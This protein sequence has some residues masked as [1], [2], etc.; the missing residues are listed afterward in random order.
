MV[1][2]SKVKCLLI[3]GRAPLAIDPYPTIKIS[4]MWAYI[5]WFYI[6]ELIIMIF[7]NIQV[8]FIFKKI[9][10]LFYPLTFMD[11]T[12]IKKNQSKKIRFHI[13]NLKRIKNLIKTDGKL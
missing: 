6:V 13:I 1:I 11:F 12:E 10:K 8:P 5:L 4:F 3:K 2:L 7:R 9:I